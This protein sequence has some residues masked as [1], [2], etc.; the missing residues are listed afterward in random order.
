MKITKNIKA[1]NDKLELESYAD[2]IIVSNTSIKA[3]MADSLYS[4]L[5]DALV[6]VMTSPRCGFYEDEVDD[7][8]V[9][10]IDE[11]ADQYRIE[12]RAELGYDSM[13]RLADVLNL[14]VQKY[15]SGAY[16]DMVSPGIMEAYVEKYY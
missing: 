8:S 15:D 2:P 5:Y 12:V 11:D 13:E 10:E 7:Y 6:R 14:I 1:S 4:K 3:S 9:I 16:F